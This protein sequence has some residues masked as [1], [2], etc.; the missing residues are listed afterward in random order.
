M[1]AEQFVGREYKYRSTWTKLALFGGFF[2]ACT[3]LFIYLALTNDEVLVIQ[4]VLRLS[5]FGGR[6]VYWVLA[7]MSAAF[8]CCGVFLAFTRLTSVQ[9]IAL[10]PTGIILPTGKWNRRDEAFVEFKDIA[11]VKLLEFHG[12]HYLY[13]YASGL[14]YTVDKG[15][16]SANDFDEITWV[17]QSHIPQKQSV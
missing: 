3:A 9:R 17:L 15:F 5:P 1:G 10:T 7:A 4:G 14:R 6:I 13:V 8:M 2:T 11:A 12:N 16:L